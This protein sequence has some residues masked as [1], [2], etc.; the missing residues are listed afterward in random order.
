MQGSSRTWATSRPSP[1][2]RPQPKEESERRA[3]SPRRRPLVSRQEDGERTMWDGTKGR[4][5][6]RPCGQSKEG[7]AY[8]QAMELMR[9]LG[10]A[11]KAGSGLGT[12]PSGWGS[13]GNVTTRRGTRRRTWERDRQTREQPGGRECTRITGNELG[14]SWE[15]PRAEEAFWLRH[16]LKLG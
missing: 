15:R 6:R 10:N 13:P 8:R 9:R 11:T 1:T 4:H 7:A 16:V 12:Q 5:W 3:E 2:P 14:T